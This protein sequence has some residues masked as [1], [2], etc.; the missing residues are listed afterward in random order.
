MTQQIEISRRTNIIVTKKGK[1]RVGSVQVYDWDETYVYVRGIYIRAG[2]Y[3][4]YK[5]KISNLVKQTRVSMVG[6]DGMYAMV[7]QTFYT[8]NQCTPTGAKAL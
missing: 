2:K 8:T 3:P 1:S 4:T 7:E 5:I 6:G